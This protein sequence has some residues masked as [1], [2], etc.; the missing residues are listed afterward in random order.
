MYNHPFPRGHEILN[1]GRPC[2]VHRYY[3]L[4]LSDPCYRADKKI[5]EIIK[6]FYYMT[7]SLAKHPIRV[8]K[9]RVSEQK[10]WLAKRTIYDE[11]GHA[12]IKH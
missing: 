5:F 4:R 3:I 12:V 11:H 8:V 6:H 9:M 1:I 10:A 7:S 2:L